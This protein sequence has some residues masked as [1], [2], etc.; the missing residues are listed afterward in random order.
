[1]TQWIRKHRTNLINL[2][3]Y[4]ILFALASVWIVYEVHHLGKVLSW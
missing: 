2:V 1:M 4:V 3:T